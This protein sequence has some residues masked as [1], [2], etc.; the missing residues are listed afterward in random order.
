MTLTSV[1][2]LL[3]AFAA[4]ILLNWCSTLFGVYISGFEGVVEWEGM[5]ALALSDTWNLSQ[6]LWI[7]LFP[8]LV[9]IAIY[10]LLDRLR[11]HFFNMPSWILLP[12]SWAYLAILLWVF[13][14]PFLEILNQKGIY[15]AL[16]WLNMSRLVQYI[17]GIG[18]WI[19]LF[20]R[21][22]SIARLFSRSLVVP[23]D[24][25]TTASMITRQLP[26][27]WYIPFLILI[28][29]IFLVQGITP[30]NSYFYF[31]IGIFLLILVNTWLIRRYEV[32]VK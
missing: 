23:A 26:F 25:I 4:L 1:L 20:Y 24:K 11:R 15:Y 6:V 18:L 3:F 7:Y 10:F 2:S 32:I 9:Y 12:T 29:I 17:F 13:F 30:F 22:F 31:L 21:S 28:I 16:N 19:F 27:L 8:Y 14:T 5:S